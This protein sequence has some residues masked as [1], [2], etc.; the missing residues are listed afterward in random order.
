MPI[1]LIS[2]ISILVEEVVQLLHNEGLIRQNERCHNRTCRL[3]CLLLK[4]KEA[5]F[6][7]F[8][9]CSRCQKEC[10]ILDDRFFEKSRLPIKKIIYFIWLWA[11]TTPFLTALTVLGVSKASI[12]QHYRYIRDKC[13]WKMIQT[14]NFFRLGGPEHNVQIDETVVAK[15]KYHRGCLIPEKLVLGMYNTTM[16]MGVVVYIR[17]KN[18]TTLI[19]KIT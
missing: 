4:K 8:F 5:M 12:Y 10:T 11:N 14:P 19:K 2:I 1:A 9:R 16:K 17:R 3:N 13:S 7:H 15:R 6:G 18:A